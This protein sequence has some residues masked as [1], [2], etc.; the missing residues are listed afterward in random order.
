MASHDDIA[1]ILANPKDER[2][3][4][5]TDFILNGVTFP[6]EEQDFVLITETS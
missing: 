5:G 4:K 6:Q 1:K 2:S 3:F